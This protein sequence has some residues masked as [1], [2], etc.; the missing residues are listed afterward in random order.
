MQ[1]CINVGAMSLHCI[2]VDMRFLDV[3]SSIKSSN[4][5]DK[6][7]RHYSVLICAFLIII[8][9]QSLSLS[10]SLIS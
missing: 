6:P 9:M 10:L 8:Y 2:D 1:R 5:K 7:D 3:P 4:F